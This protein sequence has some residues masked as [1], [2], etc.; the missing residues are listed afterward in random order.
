MELLDWRD[1]QPYSRLYGDVYFS[2]TSGIEET[3]HVFLQQ[4]RLDARWRNLTPGSLFTIAETGFGTG[5]NF[6]SAWQLWRETA[7]ENA[8]LHFVSME[9]YPLS[10]VEFAQALALWPELATCSATLLDQYRA[11]CPGWRRLTFDGGRVTL[12]LLLGDARVTLP[13]LHAKVDVW[14]LDG[15]A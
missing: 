12:T 1:G 3:R 9:K 4:N 11:P 6:L 5:L 13:Q 8:R 15:F 2:R 14:F 10:P 7:P